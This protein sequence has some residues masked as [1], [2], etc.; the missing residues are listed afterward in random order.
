MIHLTFNYWICTFFFFMK[1][2]YPNQLVGKL[3]RTL[4][5]ERWITAI[6]LLGTAYY[7]KLHSRYVYHLHPQECVGRAWRVC[8]W[9]TLLPCTM[10]AEPTSHSRRGVVG[11]RIISLDY[12]HGMEWLNQHY[13]LQDEDR[14]DTVQC[15]WKLRAQSMY[16]P[17]KS[18]VDDKLPWIRFF[19][20][21]D[22]TQV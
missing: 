6:S 9:S 5:L 10:A 22:G 18:E 16:H 12:W 2:K 3:P 1:C 14:S 7:A 21:S 8:Q 4:L 15:E 20:G 13:A 17:K 11:W 19:T